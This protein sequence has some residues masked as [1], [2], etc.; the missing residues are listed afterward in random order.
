MGCWRSAKALPNS[1]FST[2]EGGKSCRRLSTS[3]RIARSC[4]ASCTSA[5]D[6][7]L[8]AAVRNW[9]IETKER[10]MGLGGTPGVGGTSIRACGQSDATL[11]RVT[12]SR[13]ASVRGSVVS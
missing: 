4:T 6:G 9:A 3:I 1:D 10:S 7:H 12:V 5:L 8:A 2:R 13:S 11:S